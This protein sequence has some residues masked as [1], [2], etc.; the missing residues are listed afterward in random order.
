MARDEV[1]S[2]EGFCCKWERGGV[3]YTYTLLVMVPPFMVVYWSVHFL[4]SILCRCACSD[5]NVIVFIPY[6]TQQVVGCDGIL[7]SL[8]VEDQC[9][10]CLEPGE[11]DDQCVGFSG[12]FTPN[13]QVTGEAQLL[14]LF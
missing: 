6:I 2:F 11:E 7:G 4:N 9:L 13:T 12:T 8:K 10:R 3:D 1:F 5:F 14:D